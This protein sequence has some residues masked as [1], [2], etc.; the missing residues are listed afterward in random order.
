MAP[1]SGL[2]N[3]IVFLNMYFARNNALYHITII[4]FLLQTL[5][6]IFSVLSS[7]NIFC[8]ISI[9]ASYQIRKQCGSRM[10]QECRE[11][12][13]RHRF[14]RK[15]LVSDPGMHHGTCVAHVPWCMSGSLTHG[16]G[17]SVPGIPDTRATRNLTYLAGGPWFS[18]NTHLS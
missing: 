15:P 5:F 11:S 14:Q 18:Q 7:K 4:P 12:F 10:R 2:R 6:F 13:I 9:W 1:N 16:G 17:E 8:N 3:Y